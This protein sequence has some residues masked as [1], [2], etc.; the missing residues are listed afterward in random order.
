M[1]NELSIIGT[2]AKLIALLAILALASSC[3]SLTREQKEA[4]K[5][6][7]QESITP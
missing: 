4:F 7:N 1:I 6:L 5:I 2:H 3:S